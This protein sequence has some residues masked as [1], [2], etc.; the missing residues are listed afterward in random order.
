MD[1]LFQDPGTGL[2]MAKGSSYMS[3]HDS[4]E[5]DVPG[6]TD[7]RATATINQSSAFTGFTEASA[8]E[9]TPDSL[10]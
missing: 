5:F 4:D 10:G 7:S 1:S 2:I 6:E 3:D 8:V 9:V